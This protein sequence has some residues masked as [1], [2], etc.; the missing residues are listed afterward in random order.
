MKFDLNEEQTMVRKMAH[1]FAEKEMLP[2]L[3]DCERRREVNLTLIQKMAS[4]GLLGVHL[5]QKYGGME[6]GYVT[7]SIVWEQLSR[8]SWTQTLISLG[9]AVL[10]GTILSKVANE[11]QK[12][13]YLPD[14]CNG[15]LI[16]AM[17]AV[18]PNV[19]SDASAVETKATLDGDTWII[20]GSKNFITAGNL[21]D[22]VLVLVQTNKDL[23]PKGLALIAVE[24]EVSGFTATPAE[25]VGG[26]ASDISNLS[27]ME[28]RVPKAN[29]IG[30]IGRGL[31]N[32][33]IGID[34]ARLFVAAGA[35][36]MA[37][38]CLDAC[39]KYAKERYQFKRPI[40][41]FQLIQET[42]ARMYAEIEATRW[43]VYY[44]A[45]LKSKNAP[46]AKEL[47]AAKWLSSELA[48]RVGAEAIRLHGAYGCTNEYLVEHHYRDAIMS[49]ILGGTSEMHKLTIGREL[50]GINALS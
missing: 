19:G 37:Q 31:Q 21:A 25:M 5:P 49:T 23:G 28:C 41:G 16:V 18:E 39:V 13:K 24:K 35:I 15:S 7:A 48:V 9:H 4:Q 50:L 8:A 6:A 26:W 10:A 29:L 14:L 27:F 47:S 40:G 11:E 12:Q 43:Q 34:T 38:S 20:D 22:V 33:L 46:H 17:A 45:D 2:T 42:I 44:A 36:G 1:D 3:L 32:A 30:D